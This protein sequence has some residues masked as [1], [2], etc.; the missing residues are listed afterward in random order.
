MGLVML[1]GLVAIPYLVISEA[2]GLL[3]GLFHQHPLWFVLLC[4]PVVYLAFK[5]LK[6]LYEL[7]GAGMMAV[8]GVVDR[9]EQ[10]KK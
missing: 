2:W 3:V 8:G 7:L 10:D 6:W 1:V 5:L 9:L 4:I